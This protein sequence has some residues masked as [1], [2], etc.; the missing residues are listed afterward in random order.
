MSPSA[1]STVLLSQDIQPRRPPVLVPP[2]CLVGLETACPGVWSSPPD[3][4]G[5]CP[6]HSWNSFL[7]GLFRQDPTGREISAVASWRCCGCFRGAEHDTDQYWEIE[8]RED[9]T[10]SLFYIDIQTDQTCPSHLCCHVL[11][12]V[13]WSHR[14]QLL[15]RHHL[16]SGLHQTLSPSRSSHLCCCPAC[17]ITSLRN[18]VR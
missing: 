11:H 6:V 9:V 13:L 7:P 8:T 16:Q 14:L 4:P 5:Q 17:L 1:R 10:T 15:C 12:Q 2:G 3:A 18:L